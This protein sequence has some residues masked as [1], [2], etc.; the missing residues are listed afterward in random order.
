M[1]AD[2][3]APM[4]RIV[5]G[6]DGSSGSA[7]ALAWATARAQESGSSLLL[8][9]V[10]TYSAEF[11]R[12]LRLDTITTWRRRLDAQLR[13]EW[14]R[15]AIDAGVEVRCELLEDDS[16]AA[17]LLAASGRPDVDLVVLGAHGHGTLT[18]R[19][20][21]ATTSTVSHRARVPVLMVPPAWSRP[22]AA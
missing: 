18:D 2:R 5:V 22:A 6:L 13:D 19:L 20:L 21:G 12:D 3:T 11:G 1:N 16:A 4:R 10:L 7:W 14:A 17:G 9:R 15:P 8:V